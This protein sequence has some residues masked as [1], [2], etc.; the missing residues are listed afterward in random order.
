MQRKPS[1]TNNLNCNTKNVAQWYLSKIKR[2]AKAANLKC[3]ITLQDLEKQW[4][5][6]EGKCFLSGADLVPTSSFTCKQSDPNSGSLDRV[7][8]SI[9]YIPS[10]VTWVHKRINQMKMN[11]SNEDFVEM[12]K[13]VAKMWEIRYNNK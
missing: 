12:C 5:K 4:V 3:T 10:N 2:R 8:S 7:D 6:Q 1:V 11:I 9:G 13:S